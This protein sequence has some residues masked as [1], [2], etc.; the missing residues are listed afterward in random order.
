MDREARSTRASPENAS[1]LLV[2]HDAMQIAENMR[3]LSNEICIEL[4]T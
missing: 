3:P 1:A 4:T 2:S